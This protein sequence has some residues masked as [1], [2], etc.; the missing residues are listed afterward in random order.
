MSKIQMPHRFAYVSWF[1]RIKLPRLA[2]AH[3]AEAAVTGADV[4]AQH[5]GCCPV[6]PALEDVRAPCFLTNRVQVQSFDQPQEMILVRRI[7]QTDPQ[8][9]R[10]WLTGFLI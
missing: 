3:G 4:P 6:S 1:F 7:T 10:F 5:K 9:L 2:F 8:P